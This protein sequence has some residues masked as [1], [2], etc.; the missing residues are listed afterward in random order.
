MGLMDRDYW[1]D[2]YKERINPNRPVDHPD[3]PV[4]Q[5]FIRQENRKSKKFPGEDWHWSLKAVVWMATFIALH[6]LI[7]ALR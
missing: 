1:R 5:D 2:R 3:D 7:R 6:A 4:M